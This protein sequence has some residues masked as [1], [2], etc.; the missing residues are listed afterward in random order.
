MRSYKAEYRL[1]YAHRVWNPEHSYDDNCRMIHG[2]TADLAVVVSYSSK[3]SVHREV[4]SNIEEIF[5][6]LNKKLFNR[7]M[8]DH[9]D[10]M[11][12]T[13]V[14]SLYECLAAE[15]NVDVSKNNHAFFVPVVLP[16]SSIVVAHEVNLAPFEKA[17]NSPVYDILKS[18]F[19]TDF[20]PS[21]DNLAEWFYN[22]V[23]S[24]VKK[25]GATLDFVEWSNVPNRRIKYSQ[26]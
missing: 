19:I 17:R 8:I 24:R 22:L 16:E 5:S 23:N 1:C 13:L 3:T 12:F 15:F 20:C 9:A 4:E 25:N 10:P 7:F 2:H 11:F 26:E 14:A 6:F 21:A 18:Y